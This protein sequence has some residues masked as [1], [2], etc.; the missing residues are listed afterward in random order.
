MLQSQWFNFWISIFISFRLTRR[1]VKI[2]NQK[3]RTNDRLGPFFNVGFRIGTHPPHVFSLWSL[4]STWLGDWCLSCRWKGC[5]C[6]IFEI[7]YNLVP[8]VNYHLS[9]EGSK[10][11]EYYSERSMDKIEMYLCFVSTLY[12]YLRIMHFILWILV[13]GDFVALVTEQDMIDVWN[14]SFSISEMS[15]Q[16]LN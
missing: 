16:F 7:I 11:A 15:F 8:C 13:H 4:A 10:L 14:T 3:R 1:K 9:L 2:K 5:C 6:T 12:R